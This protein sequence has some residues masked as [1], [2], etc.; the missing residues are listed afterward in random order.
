MDAIDLSDLLIVEPSKKTTI[1]EIHNK[2]PLVLTIDNFL[3]QDEC[4]HMINISKNSMV[5]SLVSYEK[6]GTE[7]TGR[8][9]LNTWI[10]H[11]HDEITKNIGE[12]IASVVGIPL[13][14]AEAYQVIYY[15]TNAEYRNH[16][17]SWEHNGSDKTLRCMKYGGARLKTALVYLN[18]V[19]EGGSTRLNRV[20]VNVLPKQG[21][22]L[23]F[24]NTYSGTNVKHPLSEHAG[25][26]VIKG[27]KYAFNLWFKEC[28]SKRLYSEFNPA[29]YNN[30]NITNIQDTTLTSVVNSI[31]TPITT[32]QPIYKYTQ[33]SNL[34]TPFTKITDK[35]SIYKLDAFL[36]EVECKQIIDNCDF[37]KSTSKFLNCWINNKNLPNAINKIEKITGIKATFFEN[38]NI[39]KYLPNQS[40]GPFMEAYDITSENGK[41]YTEKLGQ[42]IYT[43]TVPLNNVMETKFIKINETVSNNMG[44]LLIYDNIIQSSRNS[45]DNEVEHTIYNNNSNESYFL[46]IYIRE[47]DGT[48]N[49]LPVEL[50]TNVKSNDNLASTNMELNTNTNTTTSTEASAVPED[51]TET[52]KTVLKRFE[53]DEIS[54]SWRG[55]KSFNYTFKGEFNYFKKIVL[56]YIN[57]RKPSIIDVIDGEI[58]DIKGDNIYSALNSDNLQKSYTFDEYSPVVVENV[59]NTSTLAICQKY[60]STT[61]ENGTYVLGDKQSRRF[62]SH[63]EPLSRILHYEVL[64]L[65]E[66]IVGKKVMP[67]YTY[68]SAYVNDSDLPA[69]TD[70]ADCEYT[71]SFL[72][73]KPDNSHWPIFLHKV[74]QPVKHKGRS[75]FTPPKEECIE[76]DCNA[77]GLMIF[78]GTDHIHFRENLP[79]DFY[80]IVLLHYV[81][82]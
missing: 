19:E 16:Y 4:N 64:P 31:E 36:S 66:K 48:T 9:S 54:Q 28:N 40:H 44:S 45:R 53:N 1:E 5:R 14:N 32:S 78:Q 13:E 61:I 24:E 30:N 79:D 68:L 59:L 6:Q 82:V 27:E 41:K 7:S 74:K 35:K 33:L 46:N 58:T 37:T 49:Y 42:R 62:K 67:S 80:H 23:V 72:I 75:D 26:P 17:D 51:Y 77:G 57:S 47:K 71:V 73:N 63:N 69:H 20:N 15:D 52:L 39:F 12:K 18:E 55:E 56:E 21:K 50:I 10:Q 2:E 34:T 81:S 25:M 29:Y 65:I 11:N 43:I 3:T 76:V 38:M 60:Y 8:T 70:R 22:L